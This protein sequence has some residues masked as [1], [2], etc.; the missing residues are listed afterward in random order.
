LAAQNRST[1]S[2]RR[3]SRAWS[4]LDLTDDDV[5]PI[6]EICTEQVKASGELL[7]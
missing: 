4:Y 5:E 3:R 6:L 2:I 7:T 1:G